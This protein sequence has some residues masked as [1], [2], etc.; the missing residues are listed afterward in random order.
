MKREVVPESRASSTAGGR[1]GSVAPPAAVGRPAQPRTSKVAL[2]SVPPAAASSFLALETFLVTGMPSTPR[3][4]IMASVSSDTR[5]PEMVERPS[6]RAAHTRAR[7]VIDFD[8]GMATEACG[9]VSRRCTGIGS[10]GGLLR[11]T[12]RHRADAS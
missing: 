7:L 4:S 9:G 10:T 2:P 8:P 5:A 12:F 11:L 3:Q 1:S 6:A